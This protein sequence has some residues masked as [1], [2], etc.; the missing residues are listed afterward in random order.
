MIDEVHVEFLCRDAVF[1]SLKNWLSGKPGVRLMFLVDSCPYCNRLLIPCNIVDRY[2]ELAV[3]NPVGLHTHLFYPRHWWVD[4]LVY[5]QQYNMLSNGV[6]Y[7]HQIDGDI[8][9]FAPGNWKFNRD[10]V[11]ACHEL[12]LTDFHWHE[13]PE[14][15]DTVKWG[16]KNYG[17]MNFISSKNHYTHDWTIYM[18]EG[19][20]TRL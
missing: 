19:G 4:K 13:Y 9:H 10:T 11:K 16:K 20:N 2:R 5:E 17:G 12:G 14:N 1:D 15:A 6:K 3:E 18:K 8:T 7:L